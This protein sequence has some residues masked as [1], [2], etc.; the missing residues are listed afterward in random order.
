MS[1]QLHLLLVY[2]SDPSF[3]IISGMPDIDFPQIIRER[4]KELGLTQEE[5]AEK[6]GLT[7][8]TYGR[9]ERGEIQ[10][11]LAQILKLLDAWNIDIKPFLGLKGETE[12][13][14]KSESKQLTVSGCIERLDYYLGELKKLHGRE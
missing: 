12:S 3:P 10:I 4:R 9:M 11:K 14:N 7:F 13:T 8:I 1:F 6:A 2:R 5:M